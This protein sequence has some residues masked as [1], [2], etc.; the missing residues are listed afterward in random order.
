MAEQ[1][2]TAFTL[3]DGLR[4]VVLERHQAPVAAFHTLVGGGSVNDPPGQT[5]LVT[6]LGRMQL[7]GSE[8]IG[9][10]NWAEE[11]RA[12][13]AVDE[14]RSRMDAERDKGILRNEDQ[15]GMLRTQWRLAVDAA[16]RASNS[17]EY[18]RVLTDAGASEIASWAD[19]DSMHVSYTLPSNRLEL[20]FAMEAQR[21]MHP[22]V[23]DFDQER[24]AMIEDAN[25]ERALPQARV[26]ASLLAAAFTAHPYRVPQTGWPSDEPELTRRQA[27]Q[28][29]ET[30]Y[31]PGNIV[32]TMAGDVDPAEARRLAEKYLGPMPARPMPPALHTAE[33]PQQGPRTV[34]LEQNGQALIAVAF[35]RPDYY[36]K[37]D[38]TLDVFQMALVNGKTGLARQDLVNDRKLVLKV[39]IVSTF[40]DGQYPNLFAFLLVPA[41]G[42]G[43]DDALKGLDALIERLRTRKVPADEVAAARN[44]LQSQIYQR[45]A[46]NSFMARMLAIHTWIYGDWKKMFT[47]TDAIGGVT[48]DDLLRVAQRYLTTA[49]RT[50]VYTA[51]PGQPLNRSLP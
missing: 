10:R 43:V 28:F 29:L 7:K 25:K 26:L 15:Y 48:D 19:Y 44:E 46:T 41:P 49:N 24:A 21:L 27:Q 9:S 20:W 6:L 2:V 39:E 8:S 4:I 13:E 31:V 36:D 38:S 30:H 33:P 23:R 11:K 3:A 35:K 45:L 34:V 42:R 50:T 17:A 22:V 18:R 32:M 5:G 1:Q 14:A 47:I 51:I 37:D 16:Q 12:L 40:P